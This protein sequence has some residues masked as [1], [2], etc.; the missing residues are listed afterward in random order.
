MR[1]EELFAAEQL[2]G[3]S[4]LDA[5]GPGSGPQSAIRALVLKHGGQ[6]VVLGKKKGSWH[7]AGKPGTPKLYDAQDREVAVESDG[8]WRI[9]D[10]DGVISGKGAKQIVTHLKAGGPGS[11]PVNKEGHK[12]LLDN[13][14]KHTGNIAEKGKTL[15]KYVHKDG[16]QIFMHPSG[17]TRLVRSSFKA[18][19]PR[20]YHEYNTDPTFRNGETD[21]QRDARMHN[22]KLHGGGAASGRY[23]DRMKAD[24]QKAIHKLLQVRGW[25]GSN[26]GYLHP[27]FP[28]HYVTTD[29]NGAWVY[30]TASQSNNGHTKD[31]LQVCMDRMQGKKY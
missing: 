16:T 8:S 27:D 5:G 30:K 12:G 18:K 15:S 22:D 13:G 21:V 26:T 25:R 14:F 9:F 31:Q 23:P 19:E 20:K 24:S 10:D 3:T 1:L 7:R 11:G 2:R 6:H 17:R 29:A 4:K 28:D